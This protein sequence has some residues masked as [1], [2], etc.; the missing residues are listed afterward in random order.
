VLLWDVPARSAIGDPFP[1]P[2][3]GRNAAASFTP[4]GPSVV[5][6][7]ETGAGWVWDVN[8]SDWR[9]A[10]RRPGAASHADPRTTM[11]YD[12]DRGSLDRRATDIVAAYLAG[13]AGRH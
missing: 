4:N 11:R 3:P 6:V 1:G 7:S 12:R 9:P 10:P 8:N 13:A 2:V 5:V